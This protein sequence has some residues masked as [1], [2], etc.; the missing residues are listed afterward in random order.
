MKIIVRVSVQ[1]END[2]GGIGYVFT[3][4]VDADLFLTDAELG[5]RYLAPALRQAVREM[6]FVNSDAPIPRTN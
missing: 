3:K 6:E 1:R 2:H 4:L 5:E